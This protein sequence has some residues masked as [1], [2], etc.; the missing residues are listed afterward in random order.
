MVNEKKGLSQLVVTVL[1]VGFVVIVIL[2]IWLWGKGVYVE[3]A[4]KEGALAQTQVECD[5]VSIEIDAVSSGL[6][7]RNIGGKMLK[8]FILREDLEDFFRVSNVYTDISIGDTFIFIKT[9]TTCDNANEPS[10]PGALC[11]NSQDVDITPA[12]QPEGRGAPL[13][14][15]RNAHVSIRL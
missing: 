2:T 12:L 10:T 11:G 4:Q 1:L 5:D 9:Q 13:V 6:Q 8:G 7:A 3:Q 14:P 15:C